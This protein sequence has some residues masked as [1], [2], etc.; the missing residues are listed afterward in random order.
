MSYEL[1]WNFSYNT[2]PTDQSTLTQQCRSFF[3]Q[4]KNYL[5]TTAGWVVTESSN[6]SITA[7][8]D[9][10]SALTDIVAS[11]SAHSWI[12]LK[13]PIGYVAGNNGSYTGD[14]SRLWMTIAFN[15]STYYTA[16]IK[17]HTTSPT[18]G[19]TSTSPSSPSQI[20]NS[21]LQFN[22][23]A[24]NPNAKFHF[25]S[26]TGGKFIAMLGY[27]GAGF[28][29]YV[30]CSL[31]LSNLTVVG[32][33]GYDYPFGMVVCWSWLDSGI[34]ALTS[35]AL[36]AGTNTAGF[37]FD[38]SACSVVSFSVLSGPSGTTWIGNGFSATGDAINGHHVDSPIW[39]VGTTTNK[40]AKW[41]RI[42]DIFG[43]GVPTQQGSVDDASISYCR[44]GSLWLPSNVAIVV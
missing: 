40:F 42:Q 37:N 15:A 13:A 17:F 18:G 14:Q 44:I 34:G 7:T 2:T 16:T 24:L 9:L 28:I 36:S 21:S 1:T 8:S 20:T 35:S 26:C 31:P 22:R 29:P 4:L 25:A 12:V 19:N 38:E 3:M 30:L 11:S 6:S 33:T 43:S 10:W 27:L 39:A 5:V 41:G 32:S 23:N